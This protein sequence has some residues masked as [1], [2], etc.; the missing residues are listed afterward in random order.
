MARRQVRSGFELRG[1]GHAGVGNE[2]RRGCGLR[3]VASFVQKPADL[4]T[5]GPR[6]S[7]DAAA[8]FIDA[9]ATVNWQPT[10]NRFSIQ[11]P[12]GPYDSEK[13]G[14]GP[15]ARISSGASPKSS[16]FRANRLANSRA[17]AS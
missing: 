1:C 10:P 17:L 7:L 16:K 13:S 6:Y 4:D 14:R 12:V 3:L 9:P 11:W 2:D 15:A 5:G 8:P